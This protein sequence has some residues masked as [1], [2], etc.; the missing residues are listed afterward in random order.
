[1]IVII[2]W[3]SF[4]Y[5][6]STYYQISI[7][8]LT[9]FL[10]LISGKTGLYY[11]II[12]SIFAIIVYCLGQI[13]Y[14]VELNSI[15]EV[16]RIIIWISSFVFGYRYTLKFPFLGIALLM[17]VTIYISKFYHPNMPWISAIYAVH[18]D[19]NDSYHFFRTIMF[20][21]MPATSGYIFAM[22][23]T[24]GTLMYLKSEISAGHLIIG[25]VVLLVLIFSTLS[26][27][28]L[29]LFCALNFSL[30]CVKSK[31]RWLL[32]V[33]LITSITVTYIFIKYFGLTL[34][35]RWTGVGYSTSSHRLETIPYVFNLLNDEIYRLFPGCLFHRGCHYDGT[36]RSISTDGGLLY[37]IINWGLPLISVLSI[38]IF[39]SVIYSLSKNQLSY[40]IIL[41]LGLTVTLVDPL[42]TDPKTAALWMITLGYTFS[43]AN[44]K[45]AWKITPPN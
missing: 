17:A 30:L 6:S 20:A 27:L 7:I 21:G 44:Q 42:G 5:Y 13:A 32:S 33:I 1:M 11:S 45:L 12:A 22:I 19:F 34:P 40:V 41:V 28:P 29:V 43:K 36:I 9:V 25:Y 37:L 23:S 15:R 31:S 35:S 8:I 2:L 14:G 26:R 4:G 3:P 39:S 18:P 38:L 24:W 10:L 16:L